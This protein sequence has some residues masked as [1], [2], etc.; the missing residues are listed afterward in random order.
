[1]IYYT[2]MESQDYGVLVFKV[3]G[4]DTKRE[5]EAAVR[6]NWGQ[7]LEQG[8]ICDGPPTI[9]PLFSNPQQ[10]QPPGQ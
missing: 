5:A 8:R 10:S 3:I 1:M 2:T 9:C 6:E 7:G 4:T